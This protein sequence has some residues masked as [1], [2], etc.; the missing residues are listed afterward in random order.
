MAISYFEEG[1][2]AG[3]EMPVYELAFRFY[4]NGVS[5]NL[6]INYGDFSIKGAL[7]EIEFF[8]ADVCEEKAKE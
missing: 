8:Q 1:M 4:A 6:L 2:A 3:E 7:K 5:R